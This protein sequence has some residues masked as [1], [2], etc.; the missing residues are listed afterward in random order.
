ML[1]RGWIVLAGLLIISG[2]VPAEPKGVT[3]YAAAS[4]TNVLQTIGDNFTRDTGVPVKFSFAASSTLA[5]QVEAASPA[6]VFLSADQQWMDYL[7]QRNRIQKTTRIDLLGNRLALIA[8]ADS[9]VSL[10]IGPR[11]PL[12]GA[13]NGGR[14][15]TGD[16]DSVPVGRYARS[17]LTALGVWDQVVDR[18]VRAEDVRAAMTFVARG[19]APLG[20]VYETD[21]KVD[22]RVRVV[23]LFPTDSHPPITYPVAL[24]SEASAE[25]L[26]FL[27]YLR[28]PAATAVFEQFGFRVLK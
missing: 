22:K 23:A 27:G 15:A 6:D 4:L 17:A 3:V 18:L 20:I 1:R 24:T 26:R 21:A 13:L 11:F 16:P 7:E 14:L 5:R 8:P 9:T 25:A 12:V 2:A 19:E 28:T 10:A